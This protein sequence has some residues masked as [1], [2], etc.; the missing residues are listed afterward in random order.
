M[1][2]AWWRS[3]RGRD[4]AQGDLLERCKLPLFTGDHPRDDH[5]AVTESIIQMRVIIVTQSCDLEHGKAQFVALCPIHTLDEVVGAFPKFANK[6][7]LEEL[8]K[9]RIPSR[10]MLSS[11]EK[12]DDNRAVLLA[13]LSL[14]TSL[15]FEYLQGH[16]ESLGDRWRLQSPFLEHFSQ[17]FARFFMRVG[18]PSDI[19]PFK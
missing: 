17:A 4:L 5:E 15:P 3:V 16:A 9:G 10:H 11:P 19:P 13:D 12:P 14:I 18:L 2:A 8:R 7:H 6:S 1:T